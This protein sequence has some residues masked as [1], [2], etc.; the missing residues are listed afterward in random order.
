MSAVALH[1]P[2]A[3]DHRR[4]IGCYRGRRS[5]PWTP[6]LRLAIR[7]TFIAVLLAAPLALGALF[8]IARAAGG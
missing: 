5:R 7:V 1:F 6:A 3:S 4:R 2:F 8:Y